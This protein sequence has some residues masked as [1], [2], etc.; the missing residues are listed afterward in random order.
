MDA[1][2]VQASDASPSTASQL[3]VYHCPLYVDEERETGDWGLADVNII[4]KVPLHAR[5]NPVLCSLR[6]VRLVSML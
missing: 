3:P 4:T 2:N 1:S 6:R 5:L